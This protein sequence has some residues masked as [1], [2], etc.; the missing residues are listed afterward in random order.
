[1]S[2]AAGAVDIARL[3]ARF[4]LVQ[5]E[6]VVGGQGGGFGLL[7]VT[8]V[9]A[10]VDLMWDRV[11]DFGQQYE[12]DG[13]AILDWG[14]MLDGRCAWTCAASVGDIHADFCER[15][16]EGRSGAVVV[17]ECSWV[18]FETK[19]AFCE[20]CAAVFAADSGRGANDAGRDAD[21]EVSFCCKEDGLQISGTEVRVPRAA[22]FVGN[23]EAECALDPGEAARF[24]VERGVGWWFGDVNGE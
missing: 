23:S 8:S 4:L 11:L 22:G 19:D 16:E 5:F 14:W 1:M 18:S 17:G 9:A 2:D 6:Y 15:C 24:V 12:S 13:F 21:V 3:P 20:Y 7:A 10:A